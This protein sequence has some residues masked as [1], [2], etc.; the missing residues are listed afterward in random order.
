MMWYAATEI[1]RFILSECFK[2]NVSI[3]NLK[4]QKMLYFIWV[5]F[6][7][8][9]KRKLFFDEFCA[10]QLGPVIPK[11]YY[12]YCSYAGRPICQYYGDVEVDAE[13]QKILKEI[14]SKYALVS[15]NELVSMTHQRG[16]A[17]DVIYQDGLGNRET[18]PFELIIRKEAS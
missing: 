17:W 15:A 16:S 13:D 5:D 6:Y 8:K 18:I 2:R 7:K 11:V 10:W 4:L 14:I 1:A 3:S 9:T 12:E